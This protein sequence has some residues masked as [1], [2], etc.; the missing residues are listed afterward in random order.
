M[1]AAF[2]AYGLPLKPPFK[3]AGGK[4]R[5]LPALIKRLPKDVHYLKYNEPFFGGGALFFALHPRGWCALNDLNETLIETLVMIRDARG[6]VIDELAVLKQE[7][8]L[9][10]FM[11]TREL[12]SNPD[13]PSATRAAAFLYLNRTAFNGLWRVNKAG[14]FN[15]P[16]GKYANPRILDIETLNATA[17]ALRGKLITNLDF[18]EATKNCRTGDFVYFDPPYVPTSETASF[19]SYTEGGFGLAEQER[20]ARAFRRLDKRGAQL[21]LS[22]SNTK[23]VRQL[24][25][26]FRISRVENSRSISCKGDGRGAVTELIIRNY[27]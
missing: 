7:H 16:F 18:E 4:T 11:R 10:T 6:E 17:E 3:W 5:L 13:L 8:S 9:E 20:L 22:Q 27:R 12:V 1:K 25:K 15:V 14:K 26:G 24:Y 2:D 21:M 23:L 19:T